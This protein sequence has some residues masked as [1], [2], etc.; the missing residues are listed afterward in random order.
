M[1]VNLILT[2]TF[3]CDFSFKHFN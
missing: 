1:N 2:Q 3:L